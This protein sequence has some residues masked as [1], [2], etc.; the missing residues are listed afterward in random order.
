M[1]V[2]QYTKQTGAYA[3]PLF[4]EVP[5]EDITKIKGT[6]HN[7]VEAIS[8]AVTLESGETYNFQG[9]EVSQSRLV[10]AG[11]A[12]DKKLV[13]SIEWKTLENEI[14]A[15][16]VVDVATILLAAGQEQTDLWF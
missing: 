6:R 7:S 5:S 12:M 15:L 16:T 11:W 8:V 9:D 2:E 14:V 4:R 13:P 1:K 3:R 10:R